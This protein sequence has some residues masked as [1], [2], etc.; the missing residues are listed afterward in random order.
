[1]DAV[2]IGCAAR[3]LPISISGTPLPRRLLMRRK[4]Y[5]FRMCVCECVCVCVCTYGC[6]ARE[7]P[8]SISGTPLPRRLLMRRKRYL[9]RMCV[10]EC[11]C[12]CVHIWVCCAGACKPSISGT[13]YS[14]DSYAEEQVFVLCVC[15]QIYAH[16]EFASWGSRISILGISHHGI[17]LM[18]RKG[19]AYRV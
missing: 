13:L 12:V 10:C 9:F 16:F 1:L 7:L 18:R 8:I 15:V 19:Y 6:A 5:L 4:R 14:G 3:E 17:L 11:V 2:I